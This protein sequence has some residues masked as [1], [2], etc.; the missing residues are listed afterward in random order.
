VMLTVVPRL[1]R[2]ADP[3]LEAYARI[4][5]L[6]APESEFELAAAETVLR[7]ARGRAQAK[8][9][10]RISTEPTMG[11]PAEEII[12]AAKS[13]RA[14]LVVVGSRGYGRLAG[15]LVGSVAQKVVSLAP[16]PI[17]VVR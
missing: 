17:V 14:D 6:R 3:A 7:G 9:A 5:H 2:V 4:E 11:D 8:G 10:A 1:A 15:L 12:A 13:R 16:C